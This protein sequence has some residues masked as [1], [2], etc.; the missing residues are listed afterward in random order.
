MK[1]REVTLA[2]ASAKAVEQSDSEGDCLLVAAVA[3]ALVDYRRRA[4]NGG[5]EEGQ[6]GNGQWRLMARWEQLLGSR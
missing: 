5:S 6:G 2:G 4:G 3:A 1:V